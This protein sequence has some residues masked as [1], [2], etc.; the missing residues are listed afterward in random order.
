MGP[1]VL[2][3]D[4]ETCGLGFLPEMAIKE[5]EFTNVKMTT[6]NGLLGVDAQQIRMNNVNIQPQTGPAFHFINSRN[7]TFERL[8]DQPKLTTL[9]KLTGSKTGAIRINQSES[10]KLKS[11]IELEKGAR[12]D[13]IVWE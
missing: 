10:Q 8:K 1:Q 3:P 12:D 13:V 2:G 6:K 7:L 4:V 11:K 9:V 5:I